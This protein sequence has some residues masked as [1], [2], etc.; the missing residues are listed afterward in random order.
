MPPLTRKMSKVSVANKS[1]EDTPKIT[2]SLAK[3][4]TN[5]KPSLCERRGKTAMKKLVLPNSPRFDHLQDMDPTLSEVAM[6]RLLNFVIGMITDFIDHLFMCLMKEA[7]VSKDCK[8]RYTFLRSFIASTSCS[9]NV[10]EKVLSYAHR[11]IST[12][13]EGGKTFDY[14]YTLPPCR[15]KDVKEKARAILEFLLNDDINSGGMI[16][17]L[18]Q[19]AFELSN[20]YWMLYKDHIELA[21]RNY[22]VNC[23]INLIKTLRAQIKAD[24]KQIETLRKTIAGGKRAVEPNV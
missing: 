9:F 7:L 4:D 16:E 13:E 12:L 21:Y 17:S 5:A 20:R 1:N 22:R 11:I 10:I 19:H 14:G 2:K 8:D 3:R 6:S 24:N 18:V 23:R 15:V